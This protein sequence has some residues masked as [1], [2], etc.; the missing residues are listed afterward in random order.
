MGAVLI[1]MEIK[2]NSLFAE[3]L[4][5]EDAVFQGDPPVTARMPEKSRRCFFGD[6]MLQRKMFQIFRGRVFSE[7]VPEGSLMAEFS[8]ADYRVTEYKPVGAV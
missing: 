1:D 4:S 5:K 7:K 8:G 3:G 6:M 2:G